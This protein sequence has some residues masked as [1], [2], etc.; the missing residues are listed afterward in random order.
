MPKFTVK[1]KLILNDA[2]SM[3]KTLNLWDVKFYQLSMRQ[4]SECVL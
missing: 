1:I 4:I 2:K 3:Y